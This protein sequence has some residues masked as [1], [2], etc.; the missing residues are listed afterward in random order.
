MSLHVAI[1]EFS[2]KSLKHG[3]P[4]LGT[5]YKVKVGILIQEGSKRRIQNYQGILIAK[6]RSGR[7]STI[8]VR[9][10]FQGIGV[11]RTF[12]LH[13]NSIRNITIVRHAKVRRA[14]L[15]YLRNLKGKSIRLRERF[16]KS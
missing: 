9:R 5:G 1:H 16:K 15:F 8:T 2:K 4:T 3:I 6:H 12:F 10:V 13:S 11:E 7:S 14:K